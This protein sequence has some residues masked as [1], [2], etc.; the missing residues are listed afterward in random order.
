MKANY[1]EKEWEGK[2]IPIGSFVTSYETLARELKLSLRNIRTALEH[3]KSTGEVTCKG[4]SQHSIITVKNYLNY[5][6]ID[7]QNDNQT[8]CDRQASD[9]QVT[10]ER[11]TT[12]KQPTTTNK[13]KK[14]IKEKYN[15]ATE[16]FKELKERYE[17]DGHL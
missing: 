1:T 4:T 11:Q 3:L 16:M 12:D 14:E 15:S 9:K 2:K 7:M 5:Q 13:R 10:N 6:K 8:T 17:R